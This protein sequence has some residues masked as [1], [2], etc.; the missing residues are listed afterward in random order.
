MNNLRQLKDLW[1]PEGRFSWSFPISQAAAVVLKDRNFLDYPSL[2]NPGAG[3][4]TLG[5]LIC[6]G[7]PRVSKGPFGLAL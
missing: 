5:F 4:T 6:S 2:P 3:Y 7:N 1:Q